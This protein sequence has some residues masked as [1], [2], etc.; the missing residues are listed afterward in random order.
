[1]CRFRFGT[2]LK[3]KLMEKKN[4]NKNWTTVEKLIQINKT[5][6]ELETK[7]RT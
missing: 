2:K 3:A 4:E 1:M 7:K 5:L 6:E